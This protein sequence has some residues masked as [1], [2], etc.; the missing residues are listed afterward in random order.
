MCCVLLHPCFFLF[1]FFKNLKEKNKWNWMKCLCTLPPPPPLFSWNK[2]ING[3]FCFYFCVFV[4]MNKEK[5]NTLNVTQAHTY[6]TTVCTDCNP[7][8]FIMQYIQKK[9]KIEN[10]L[11]F[12][13]R[14][15]IDWNGKLCCKITF[16]VM[17]LYCLV[18]FVC[19]V[20]ALSVFAWL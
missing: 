9:K 16:Q 18:F 2:K 11:I 19:A 14:K 4:T 5:G 20:F 10:K 17:F 6:R 12:G 13:R 1:F 7:S 3:Y 15:E 8:L